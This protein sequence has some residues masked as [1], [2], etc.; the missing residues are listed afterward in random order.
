MELFY[1][2]IEFSHRKSSEQEVEENLTTKLRRLFQ[3]ITLL[4]QLKNQCKGFI[5]QKCLTRFVIAQRFKFFK[6]KRNRKKI[7][8]YRGK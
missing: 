5:S 4:I 8:D 6:Q 2:L 3:K 1:R 7:G